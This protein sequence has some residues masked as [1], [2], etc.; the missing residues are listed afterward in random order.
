MLNATQ[1]TGDRKEVILPSRFYL[2]YLRL[3]NKMIY[4]ESI[5]VM[6]EPT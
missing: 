3:I 4:I 1:K 2:R 6:D 5:T